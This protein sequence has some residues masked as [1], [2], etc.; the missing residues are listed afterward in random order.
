[1]GEE[2]AATP[3][4]QRVGGGQVGISGLFIL[5]TLPVRRSRPAT[6]EPFVDFSKSIL[7]TSDAY[8]SRME[9]MSVKRTDVAKAKD[10]RKVAS[11]E[12]K[13][14]CEENRLVQMQKK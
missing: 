14:K 2:V 10:A 5:P 3:Q 9:H 8:L 6:A 7:L 1:V 12:R 13:R 4:D 11:K